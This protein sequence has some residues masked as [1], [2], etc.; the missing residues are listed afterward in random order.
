MLQVAAALLDD[1]PATSLASPGSRP[2]I[3]VGDQRGAH[4]LSPRHRGAVHA[5]SRL[6]SAVD[7]ARRRR[8]CVGFGAEAAI[9][10]NRFVANGFHEHPRMIMTNSVCNSGRDSTRPPG[11]A[12]DRY[13]DPHTWRV[14]ETS[15]QALRR[16]RDAPVARPP[17]VSDM[18]H[19]VGA[20]S[21]ADLV[22]LAQNI[23]AGAD[24]ARVVGFHAVGRVERR[25][26]GVR[27]LSTFRDGVDHLFVA[28]LVVRR[29]AACGD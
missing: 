14:D 12:T 22:L 18:G 21:T 28:A 20:I 1:M 17:V 4:A 5:R 27:S 25:G 2:G 23:R 11:P 13:R 15:H 16:M 24:A 9:L 19:L 10:D 7:P 6:G 29:G 26:R 3:E 8:R